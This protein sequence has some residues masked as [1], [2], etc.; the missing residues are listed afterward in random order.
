ML[1][2]VLRLRFECALVSLPRPRSCSSRRARPVR[3]SGDRRWEIA[4]T[5]YGARVA[6]DFYDSL[7]V[8]PERIC[9]A[10]SMSL[11]AA[12]TISP[13]SRPRKR[14]FALW[15]PNCL[16]LRSQRIRCHGDALSSTQSPSDGSRGGVHSCRHSWAAITRICT[17]ATPM[18]GIRRGSCATLL[19][20]SNFRPPACRSAVLARHLRRSTVGMEKGAVLLLVSRGVVEASAKTSRLKI[21]IRPGTG[22]RTPGC[23]RFF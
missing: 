11:G 6:G 15:A 4:A 14:F 19:A 20:L 1:V 16:R 8:G 2:S 12:R 23:R 18:P 21:G 10:C 9:L 13:S 17:S 22:K 5:T 3:V 7:R